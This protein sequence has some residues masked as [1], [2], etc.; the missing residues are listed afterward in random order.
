MAQIR[1]YTDL[2]SLHR[3]LSRTK[4]KI[5]PERNSAIDL[6]GDPVSG[7]SGIRRS[8]GAGAGK[9]PAEPGPG[10]DHDQPVAGPELVA[11]PGRPVDRGAAA[12]PERDQPYVAAIVHVVHAPGG[13]VG[14]FADGGVRDEA[15]VPPPR[16]RVQ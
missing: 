6:W 9:D 10:G 3:W 16:D 15:H 1:P 8:P 12:A 2:P 11:G 13:Q 4:R 14:A 7:A 5:C